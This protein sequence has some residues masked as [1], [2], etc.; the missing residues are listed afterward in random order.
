M[1]KT[2]FLIKDH[3]ALSEIGMTVSEST[4][5]RVQ[6]DIKNEQARI[7]K[8]P[9]KLQRSPSRRRKEVAERVV[10]EIHCAK[11]M[12]AGKEARYMPD[13]HSE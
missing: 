8:A 12:Q 10:Q 5:T 2:A 7:R 3:A 4:I 13:V 1:F 6:R 9:K 11:P